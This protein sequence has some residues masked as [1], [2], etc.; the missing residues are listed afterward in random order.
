MRYRGAYGEASL[1]ED[2]D[3]VSPGGVTAVHNG[4]RAVDLR[5]EQSVRKRKH[6]ALEK[7]HEKTSTGGE[8]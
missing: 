2:G 3:V 6:E 4:A 8:K 7:A 1:V 5:S